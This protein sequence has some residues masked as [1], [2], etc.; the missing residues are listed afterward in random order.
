MSEA[1]W[2][3]VCPAYG[4]T[5]QVEAIDERGRRHCDIPKTLGVFKS[6]GVCN[7]TG[8][9]LIVKKLRKKGK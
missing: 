5:G 8:K 2:I 6:F 4:G 1:V 9:M 3:D 7:G